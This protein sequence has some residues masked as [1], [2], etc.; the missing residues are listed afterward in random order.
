MPL[1]PLDVLIVKEGLSK[2]EK[3]LSVEKSP[4][5]RT[6]EAHEASQAALRLSSAAKLPYVTDHSERTAIAAE[7]LT[8]P[9]SNVNKRESI[10]EHI[11]L[12]NIHQHLSEH[13]HRA[14]RRAN[15]LNHPVLKPL[16]Q[17]HVAATHAHVAAAGAIGAS[18]VPTKALVTE[19]ATPQADHAHRLSQQ[20]TMLHDHPS[21]GQAVTSARDARFHGTLAQDLA[22]DKDSREGDAR[23]ESA[24]HHLN[25]MGHHYRA[26]QGT[27]NGHERAA[28]ANALVQNRYAYSQVDP[29]GRHIT[30]RAR[31]ATERAEDITRRLPNGNIG[32]RNSHAL[33]G[34][35][36]F[37]AV[38]AADKTNGTYPSESVNSHHEN[39]LRHHADL[40][41]YHHSMRLAGEN[42]TGHTQAEHL[43]REAAMWHRQAINHHNDRRLNKETF[44]QLGLP[45]EKS[46]SRVVSKGPAEMAAAR[47]ASQAALQE[48]RDSNYRNMIVDEP[49]PGLTNARRAATYATL[50]EEPH[51]VAHDTILDK[52]PRAE[53]FTT[54]AVGHHVNSM[55]DHHRTINTPVNYPV[56]QAHQSLHENAIVAHRQAISSIDPTGR[57]LALAAQKATLAAR[58][59]SRKTAVNRAGGNNSYRHHEHANDAVDQAALAVNPTEYTSELHHGA[60]AQ[61]HQRLAGYHEF[62]T[63]MPGASPH[64]AVAER[65]HREAQMLHE[66]A[67]LHHKDNTGQQKSIGPVDVLK[68]ML[69]VVEK[70]EPG[71]PQRRRQ[72]ALA[73][74]EQAL[75]WMQRQHEHLRHAHPGLE[76]A[77]EG[78]EQA[79]IARDHGT[80]A[81]DMSEEGH[82][83]AAKMRRETINGHIDS[84][85][86]HHHAAWTPEEGGHAP[87]ITNQHHNNNAIDSHRLA[88]SDSDPDMR[89]LAARAHAASSE[90]SV[91]TGRAHRR[92]QPRNPALWALG[93]SQLAQGNTEEYD[94]VVASVN[95]RLH[96]H[97]EAA[98]WHHRM[99]EDHETNEQIQRNGPNGGHGRAGRQHRLAEFLH[100]QM[101]NYLEPNHAN[102]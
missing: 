37:N 51:N 53:E 67:A 77:E 69:G 65:L 90:A 29:E 75:G 47:D 23:S 64:H 60:A 30:E 66:Q 1:H 72:E 101:V 68:G 7:R 80:F 32:W 50:A 58:T 26:M 45:P 12:A 61:H 24:R 59:A 82:P 39:S 8:D 49:H 97:R 40:V 71:I 84:M 86:A 28:Q 4:H 16:L 62:R 14:E 15:N 89:S 96:H 27:D 5:P 19:K 95:N 94:P 93:H 35:A 74:S 6:L 54:S 76:H 99:A 42:D 17:A 3:A 43:H 18:G 63:R 20:A 56:G 33:A 10:D 2:L 25:S 87:S 91:L 70:A 78:V 57:H 44:A 11:R 46:L 31:Q 102:Q 55:L 85:I 36:A 38:L 98:Y 52:Y 100:R 92:H 81:H 34:E 21:S 41:S 88:L 13:V 9:H 83:D 48:T 22:E 73:A 79:R